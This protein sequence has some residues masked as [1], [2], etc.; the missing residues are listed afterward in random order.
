MDAESLA[1]ELAELETQRK[2]AADALQAA[3]DAV[4][5]METTRPPFWAEEK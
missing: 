1:K 3:K 4:T 5:A 2:A